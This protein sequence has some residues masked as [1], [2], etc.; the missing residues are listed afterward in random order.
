MQEICANM[1]IRKMQSTLIISSNMLKYA[2]QN[3]L[4]YAKYH[5]HEYQKNIHKYAKPN[6]HKYAFSK[7]V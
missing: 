3:M 7:H 6:T 1:Q 5:M 4:I 2:N